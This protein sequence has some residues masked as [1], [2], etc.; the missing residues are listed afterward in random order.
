MTGV[1]D[2]KILDT[3][4]KSGEV[5]IGE[6]G[7]LQ[8]W[9]QDPYDPLATGAFARNRAESEEYDGHFPE[10]PLSRLRTILAHVQ[11]TLTVS[12]EVKR[13]PTVRS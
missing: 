11:K 4:L 10:H 6:K 7:R 1:R 12:D 2:S 8:G 3:L 13:A 9:M 5:T